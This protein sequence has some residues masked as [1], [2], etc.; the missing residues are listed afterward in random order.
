MLLSNSLSSCHRRQFTRHPVCLKSHTPTDFRNSPLISAAL[1]TKDETCRKLRGIELSLALHNVCVLQESVCFSQLV[2]YV[3]P[4]WD[5]QFNRTGPCMISFFNRLLPMF[6][7][8]VWTTHAHPLIPSRFL[9]TLLS[10]TQVLSFV[11][12]TG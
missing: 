4:K 7:M 12:S 2:L 3:E 6:G 5:C 1:L 10:F 11:S 9:I 8:T